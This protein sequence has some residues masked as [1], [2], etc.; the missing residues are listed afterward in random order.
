MTGKL[1][2][3]PGRRVRHLDGREGMVVALLPPDDEHNLPRAV[4]RWDAG[5][6]EP[7]AL[8][9]LEPLPQTEKVL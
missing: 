3:E 2:I 6:A 5:G 8:G 7:I 1:T 4:V 9:Y